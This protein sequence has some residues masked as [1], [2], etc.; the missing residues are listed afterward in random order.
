VNTPVLPVIEALRQ[1]HIEAL[2]RRAAGQPAVV[3]RLLQARLQ[4]LREAPSLVPVDA[5]PAARNEPLADLLAHIAQHS[6][7][8]STAELK[9]VRD[10]RSTW[11][12]LGVQRRLTQSSTQVPHNA[13][14]LNTQR[15]LHEALTVL[16]DT[17]PAYLQRLVQQ[18]EALLA[19]EQLN[20]P[21]AAVAKAAAP[22][23]ARPAPAP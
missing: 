1:R 8:A 9:A 19:L 18:V 16:N 12:R 21:A 13:G 3:Q 23:K 10:Y 5:T 20:Q 14:P 15:L 11:S 17:S 22:K 6:G 2:E 4:Q 7:A